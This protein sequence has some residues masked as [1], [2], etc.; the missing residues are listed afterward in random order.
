MNR[1][2]IRSFLRRIF[3][4]ITCTT[5]LFSLSSCS[6]TVAGFGNKLDLDGYELV[7]Y[8]EFDADELDATVWQ[9]R[10]SGER[11]GGFNGSDQVALRD[12]KLV[13]TAEYATKEYGEGWYTGMISLVE[14]YTYGYF[15]IRCLPNSSEDFWSAFWLQS[16]NS[17][18]HLASD[19]GIGGAEIDV[20]ETYKD[21]SITTKNFVY[22]SIHCNGY[23]DIVD[24]IDSTRIVKTYIPTL[25]SEYTTFGLLW[26][27]EE[28]VFYV[29]GRETG[30]SSFG[31]GVST[32]PEEVIVSLEI[33]DEISLDKSATTSFLVDYVKIYQLKK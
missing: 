2:K 15:E 9:H 1:Q 27:E 16:I 24:Q 29:N 11:R 10:N 22:T 28:Y 3:L 20:F 6:T 7:F 21:H 14:N 23:D 30:R 19:G 4:Y 12:G 8:D 33:P 18:D 17:Y 13:I 31:N 5:L 25:R 32:V 26:T